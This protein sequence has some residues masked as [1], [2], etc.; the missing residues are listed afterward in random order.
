M[1]YGELCIKA[2]V[3]DEGSTLVFYTRK[4]KNRVL[5]ENEEVCVGSSTTIEFSDKQTIKDT[6]LDIYVA[7]TQGTC[8]KSIENGEVL[9]KCKPNKHTTIMTGRVILE[10][11]AFKNRAEF[12]AS[13]FKDDSMDVEDLGYFNFTDT[14]KASLVQKTLAALEMVGVTKEEAMLYKQAATEDCY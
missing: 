2:N 9:W 8:Y 4:R 5:P 7:A 1:Y 6:L 13:L 3:K 12:H 14:G 11:V 10:I